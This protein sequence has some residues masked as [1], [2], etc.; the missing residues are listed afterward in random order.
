MILSNLF[1]Y[2]T[3]L[4]KEVRDKVLRYDSNKIT[5][6][7][8]FIV[9]FEV[10]RVKHTNYPMLVKSEKKSI[11][12]GEILFNLTKEDFRKLDNFEGE[13]YKKKALNVIT[14]DGN[15]KC[16]VY[17]AINKLKFEEIWNFDSWYKY[18]INKFFL[19]D[20]NCSGVKKPKN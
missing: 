3:L 2:G 15:L 12:N 7:K 10:R 16:N 20:F 6:K 9:G 18:D 1:C 13:N 5:V 4:A 14:N 17:V 8:G 11:V 19:E